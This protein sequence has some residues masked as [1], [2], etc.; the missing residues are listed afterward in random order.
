MPVVL[1]RQEV[2][3]LL[4]ELDGVSWITAML[5]YGAGLRLM[6]C[7]RLRV[8]DI[9]FTRNEILLR[10]GKGNKPEQPR[11]PAWRQNGGRALAGKRCVVSRRP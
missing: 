7:L 6:E 11:R 3:A 1:E 4:A 9:D 10:E 8:K 2:D 5:L